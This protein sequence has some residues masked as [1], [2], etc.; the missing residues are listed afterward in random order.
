[1]ATVYFEKDVIRKDNLI[2]LQKG[3]L[4]GTENSVLDD[5]YTPVADIISFSIIIKS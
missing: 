1:M 2:E 4:C 3:I 5:L